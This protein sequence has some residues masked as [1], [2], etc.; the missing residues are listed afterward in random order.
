[1]KFTYDSYIGLIHRLKSKG[2][3]FTDYYKWPEVPQPVIFRH[4]IDQDIGKAL[5]LARIEKEENV[6][7]TYF[8]LLTSEFYNVFADKNACML[9]EI[10]SMGHDIGLHFDEMNDPSIV[11]NN[12][13][14]IEKI[15]MEADV[16]MRA[17]NIKIGVVSMHQPSKDILDADLE[18]PGIV[19]SYGKLF[20]KD[21]K[22]VSDSR[23][24]WREPID[25]YVDQSSYQRLH[26]LTHAFWYNEVETDMHDTILKYINS[27]SLDRYEI[28]DK[29]MTNLSD[30][31]EK[32]EVSK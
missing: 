24:R 3:Q 30:V 12:D 5:K 31:V 27:G 21:F 26:I 6:K 23:R 11:G 1:M 17:L 32:C 15:I 22:Y 2:Y 29:N 28:F 19:N 8:V 9:R 4:D 18:I 20:F 10:S 7:S 14:I 25:E 16:L 13:K